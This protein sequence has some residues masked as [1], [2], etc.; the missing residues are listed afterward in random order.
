MLHKLKKNIPITV[1]TMS[2]VSA[3]GTP[4]SEVPLRIVEKENYNNYEVCLIY[5]CA[6]EACMFGCSC[7]F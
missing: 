6:R 3:H 1:Y 2:Q 7:C 4:H 5:I